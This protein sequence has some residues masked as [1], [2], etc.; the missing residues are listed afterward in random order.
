ME[1]LKFDTE[2]DIES[3]YIQQ[4][5][6]HVYSMIQERWQIHHDT[7]DDFDSCCLGS[8]CSHFL[9]FLSAEEEERERKA[10][11]KYTPV[12]ESHKSS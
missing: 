2:C 1:V 7:V 12:N 11:D 4:V 3:L 6:D 10:G 5:D 9:T 8:K